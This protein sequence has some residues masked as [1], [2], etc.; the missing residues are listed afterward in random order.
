MIPTLAYDDF[1]TTPTSA[2]DN[3]GTMPTSALD[4]IGTMLISALMQHQHNVDIGTSVNRVYGSL[5]F[6]KIVH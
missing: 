6:N 2:Y 3:F 5:V 4:V 1:G